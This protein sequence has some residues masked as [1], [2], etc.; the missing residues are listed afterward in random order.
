MDRT[1]WEAFDDALRDE[2]VEI[3]EAAETARLRGRSMVDAMADLAARGDRVRVTCGT[4]SLTGILTFAVGNLAILVAGDTE[5]N[6]NLAGPAIVALV[7]ESRRGG[8]PTRGGSRS[9]RARLLEFELSGEPVTVVG[10]FFSEQGAIGSVAADHVVLDRGS[11][12]MYVPLR[13]IG[14]VTRPIPPG[15]P[16]R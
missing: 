8:V 4:S 14:L 15:R 10:P 1:G 11:G 13:L 16:G 7:E 12:E 2:A 9:F 5:A 6:V 3:E